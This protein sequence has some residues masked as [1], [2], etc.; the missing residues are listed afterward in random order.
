M[1]H[2]LHV[3]GEKTDLRGVKQPASIHT[4]VSS[5]VTVCHREL[6]MHSSSDSALP[7][8]EIA[9]QAYTHPCKMTLQCCLL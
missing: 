5:G 1:Y 8:S 9:L 4:A 6:Q 2:H 7:L 3:T